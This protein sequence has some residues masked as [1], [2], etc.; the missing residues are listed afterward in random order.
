MPIS[1]YAEE[2]QELTATVGRFVEDRILPFVDAWET[3]GAIPPGLRREAGTLGYLEVGREDVLAELALAEALGRCGAAG[4]AV[5]LLTTTCAV[6]PLLTAANEVPGVSALRDRTAAGEAVVALAIA[7]GGGANSIRVGTQATAAAG[8]VALTG[9]EFGVTDA[10]DAEAA[11][12]LAGGPDGATLYVC[13]TTGPGWTSIATSAGLGL[14]SAGTADVILD[15]VPATPLGLGMPAVERAADRRRL[16]TAAASVSGAWRTWERARAYALGRQ[17]FGRPIARFQVN[18][19]ALA[20]AAGR[21]TAARQLVYDAAWR[22]ATGLDA[23]PAIA[24]A[25]R[26]ATRTVLDV[27]DTCL[28]L[29]GGYGYAMEYDVQRDWRDARAAQGVWS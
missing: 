16:M 25:R 23:R 2:H 6:L 13:Q 12:V 29:Y 22:L 21:L 18:R 9:H 4:V 1:L 5:S 28:Q 8:E 15:R 17:A 14:A 27:T 19:H 11:L 3:A 10:R 26:Y 7:Q 20:E 24:T